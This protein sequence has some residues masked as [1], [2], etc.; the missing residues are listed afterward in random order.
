MSI[1]P[2]TPEEFKRGKYT[3]GF[4]VYAFAAGLSL[5]GFAVGLYLN[6]LEIDGLRADMVKEDLHLQAEI[7][8]LRESHAAIQEAINGRIDRKIQ[9]HQAIYH[10]NE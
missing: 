7:D 10:R 1:G 6:M 4:V 9:N 3:L 5:G 8:R 2:G